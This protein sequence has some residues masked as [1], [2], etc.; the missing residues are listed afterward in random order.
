MNLLFCSTDHQHRMAVFKGTLLPLAFLLLARI[1]G[2]SCYTT[3]RSARNYIKVDD[4]GNV[5]FSYDS[6]FNPSMS[7]CSMEAYFES[8][9]RVMNFSLF[10]SAIFTTHDTETC[11]LFP[12]DIYDLSSSGI[13]HYIRDGQITLRSSDKEF[14]LGSGRFNPPAYT[15][16]LRLITSPY[17]DML[18]RAESVQNWVNSSEFHGVYAFPVRHGFLDRKDSIKYNEI[19]QGI[20]KRIAGNDT[21]L[22]IGGLE[23]AFV[24]HPGRHLTLT[25]RSVPWCT[26]PG[27]E[28]KHPTDNTPGW[29]LLSPR[30]HCV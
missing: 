12:E 1:L 4:N 6:S 19:A 22:I 17:T 10:V 25:L 28:V 30:A 14:V 7:E 27:L 18:V 24:G 26:R 20:E 5:A 15:F 23:E 3:G 21:V 29:S 13:P 9:S 8:Y 16:C 2:L 11:W